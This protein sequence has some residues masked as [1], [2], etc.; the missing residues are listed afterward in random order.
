MKLKTIEADYTVSDGDWETAQELTLIATDM[1]RRSIL[2]LSQTLYAVHESSGGLP[3]YVLSLHQLKG[4]VIGS[5]GVVATPLKKLWQEY[6]KE[7]FGYHSASQGYRLLGV[8][9]CIEKYGEEDQP[10]MCLLP[11]DRL[12]WI[13]SI[14][15]PERLDHERAKE[16]IEH[17]DLPESEWMELRNE[18]WEITPQSR[19]RD[20]V[21]EN[22]PQIHHSGRQIWRSQAFRRWCRG[23]PCIF[24]LEASD[25]VDPAHVLSRGSGGDDFVNVVP[26]VNELHRLQHD[27]G[28][29]FLLSKYGQDKQ[30]LERQAIDTLISFL[31]EHHE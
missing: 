3:L 19:P 22:V 17:S 28:W 6:L 13:G 7:N 27:R 24:T 20:S 11:I 14:R 1:F 23:Q 25:R 30:W 4:D 15:H 21:T 5:D 29:T 10:E 18:I 16:A 31:K 12:G 8:A 26:V 9:R 2:A